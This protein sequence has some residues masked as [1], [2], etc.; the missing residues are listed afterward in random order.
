MATR[1]A[2]KTTKTGKSTSKKK[3]PAKTA[4]K[5][6]STT[7]KAPAKKPATAKPKMS[8]LDAAAKVLGE[9]NDPL[10]CRQMVERMTEKGYWK[11]AAGKTPAATLNAALQR[12]IKKGEKSRFKKVERGLFK[13]NT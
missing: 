4:K 8:Q 9:T 6:A 3:T 10:T 1:T 11:S 12:E 13:L 7:K 5:P 2:K